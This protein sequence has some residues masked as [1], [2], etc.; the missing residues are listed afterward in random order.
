MP[1]R[2]ILLAVI[3][4]FVWLTGANSL[5]AGSITKIPQP[6]AYPP[7]TT[8]IDISGLAEGHSFTS[9]SGGGLTVNFN[10]AMVKLTVPVNWATWNCPPATESCTPPVLWSNGAS[11]VTMNLSSA[12]HVFG[13]EAQPNLSDVEPMTAIFFGTGGQFLGDI[14]LDVSGNAGAML[15]AAFSSD[16][17]DKV[18]FSD[19][20]GNDFA[21]A[22]VSFSQS[23]TPTA[24]PASI[25]LMGTS[26]IALGIRKL[27]G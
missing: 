7:S 21:I 9:I 1:R 15:F 11:A 10:T 26:L 24:E 2:I 13:F 25:L 3:G 5:W 19:G 12:V 17:I 14:S 16:P 18:I 22:N 6:S 8:V 4:A 23:L 20:A 27:R